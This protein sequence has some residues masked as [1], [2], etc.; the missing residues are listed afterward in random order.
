MPCI[1]HSIERCTIC[2]PFT[3]T[4]TV[5]GGDPVT[6]QRAAWAIRKAME[7]EDITVTIEVK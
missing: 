5:S 3:P 4:V 2:T 1:V 7:R 6:R